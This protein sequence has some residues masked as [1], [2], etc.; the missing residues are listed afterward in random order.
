MAFIKRLSICASWSAPPIAA[1]LLFLISG[2]LLARPS[3]R[4][5]IQ[6]DSEPSAEDFALRKD[7]TMEDA[8]D[9]GSVMSMNTAFTGSCLLGPFDAAKREPDFAATGVPS[10]WEMSL[11]KH[12]FHPSVR[13]FTQSLLTPP[14]HE[15]IFDCDPIASFSIMVLGV[16][17]NI[18]IRL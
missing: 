14:R 3:L 7:E 1:G 15:I 10:L 11:L 16:S 5:T 13:T 9:N 4:S 17:Y 2:L 18:V 6:Q 12:H 8:S